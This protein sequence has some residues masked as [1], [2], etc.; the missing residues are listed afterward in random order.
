MPFEFIDLNSPPVVA[1]NF[2]NRQAVG[3]EK[4]H[5]TRLEKSIKNNNIELRKKTMAK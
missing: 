3:K 4:W 2:D 1:V 5:R